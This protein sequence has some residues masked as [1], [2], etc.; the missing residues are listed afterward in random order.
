MPFSTTYSRTKTFSNGGTLLP[1]DL[2]SIQDDLGDQIASLNVKAGVNEGSNV[3]RGKSII[4]TEE[5]RT[6]ASYGLLGT[7][8]RVQ[9]IV[10]PTDGLI[11]IAV[12]SMFKSSVSG[13]GRAAIFIGSNQLKVVD[14]D[15]SLTD[16]SVQ[17]AATG[18]TNYS[19]LTTNPSLGLYGMAAGSAYNGDVTTG[20]MIGIISA[21]TG[22]GVNPDGFD[23]GGAL[24][25]FAAAG[26][27]DVSIQYKS[28]SG[29]VTAKNRKLWVWTINF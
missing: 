7:P 28:A 10:L 6:N 23:G 4:T 20:Q 9:N 12:Q 1:G 2:N 14:R 26:T 21:A 13:A 15:G 24:Y 16:P 25:V 29:S 3:R 11:A 19:V 17:T 27:Y 18:F 5:S 22:G 8:D